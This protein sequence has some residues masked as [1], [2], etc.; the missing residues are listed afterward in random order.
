MLL[1]FEAGLSSLQVSVPVVDDFLLEAN[2]VFYGKLCSPN[3]HSS[4]PRVEFA[5]GS[6]NVTILDDD[7][8]IRSFT[9]SL[10][11]ISPCL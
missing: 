8:K 6:A 3:G 7:C 1:T 4:T 9:F 5:P 10:S 11:L 2:E